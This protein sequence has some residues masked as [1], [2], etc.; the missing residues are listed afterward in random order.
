MY[1]ISPGSSYFH[2]YT[3]SF[4]SILEYIW[5]NIEHS[6]ISFQPCDLLSGEKVNFILVDKEKW[7]RLIYYICYYVKQDIHFGVLYIINYYLIVVTQ[8]YTYNLH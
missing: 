3:K 5:L 7:D 1:N 4:P 8:S 6:I 2:E